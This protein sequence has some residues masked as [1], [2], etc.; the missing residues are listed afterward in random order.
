MVIL[1][2]RGTAKKCVG[3]LIGELEA[4]ISPDTVIMYPVFL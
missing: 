1:N 3:A 4:G 2:V